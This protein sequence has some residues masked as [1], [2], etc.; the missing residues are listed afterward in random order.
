MV[1]NYLREPVSSGKNRKPRDYVVKE[2]VV[3]ILDSRL[4]EI[5]S[6]NTEALWYLVGIYKGLRIIRQEAQVHIL[7]HDKSIASFRL[8][9]EVSMH[10]GMLS[11]L[12]NG[13]LTVINLA[14]VWN[15]I[16]GDAILPSGK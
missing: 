10:N 13:K 6:F 4:E 16:A 7:Y 5:H 2:Q 9:G 11:V 12:D 14:D 8:K 3:F 1:E 15:R